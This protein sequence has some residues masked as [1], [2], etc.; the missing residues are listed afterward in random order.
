MRKMVG[1]NNNNNDNN[2]FHYICLVKDIPSGKSRSF[3]ISNEKG[4]KIEI[5]LF[6]IDRK[7]Y[8][9]SNTCKHEG[10]P[11]S[12]GILKGKIVT[13]PWHGWKYSVIDG[14][15]SYFCVV[16]GYLYGRIFEYVLVPVRFRPV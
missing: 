9:I 16:Y 4:T 15:G 2:N 13:C 5:A 3:S 11:L 10:G 12:Q 6:N 8:A 1:Y 14:A 7:Y